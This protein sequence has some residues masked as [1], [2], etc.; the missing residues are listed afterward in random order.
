MIKL[1]I[2]LA[3]VAAIAAAST[4][5]A[6]EFPDLEDLDA[7]GFQDDVV[8]DDVDVADNVE[9]R[10][11]PS[12]STPYY[13]REDERV[14][15]RLTVNGL[16]KYRGGSP[17][18]CPLGSFRTWSVS[19]PPM[20]LSEQMQ[21]SRCR[22]CPNDTPATTYGKYN[23]NCGVSSCSACDPGLTFRRE[24]GMCLTDRQ[25]RFLRRRWEDDND[26]DVQEE[27]KESLRGG[28]GNQTA[29]LQS[30]V[31]TL[32]EDLQQVQE[33]T[34]SSCCLPGYYGTPSNCHDCPNRRPSSPY[35]AGGAPESNSGVCPNRE[36]G[37]C[38]QCLPCQEF[39]I[40]DGL[41]KQAWGHCGLS[42]QAPF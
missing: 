6:V 28:G 2:T 42:P 26:D 13:T 37:S 12:G 40:R 22:R 29:T 21:V 8:D 41:C 17:L 31:Q 34:V 15:N 4:P 19:R 38:F 14:C 7:D 23:F 36:R 24:F 32:Q 20:F 3:A 25:F 1:L 11:I 30:Q 39:D 27:V 18:Q 9:D 10:H 33:A 35:P 16:L 5:A